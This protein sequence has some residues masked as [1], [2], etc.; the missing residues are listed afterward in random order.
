M[1]RFLAIL[2]IITVVVFM[3]FRVADKVNLDVKK[4]FPFFNTEEYASQYIYVFDR[5]TGAIMYEKNAQSKTFP[6]SLTKIMT[7]IVALEH[8]DDLTAIAPIDTE[9]QSE[10]FSN[11]AMM[12]GFNAGESVTYRDLL[13]GT[14]LPS[15]AEAANSLAVHVAGSVENFVQMMNDKAIELG[16]NSTHYTSPEGLHNKDQYTTASDMGKLLD[17]AL[18][19]EDFK[20]VFTKETFQTTSTTHHPDGIFLEST[21]LAS[22]N[23]EK[24]NG[25]KIIGGKSGTTDEAGQCW[26]T[27]GL[28]DDREYIS[29]VM[30]APLEDISHPDNKQIV[31]TL[32]L[33]KKIKAGEL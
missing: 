18:D 29:I 10:M 15:G 24:Q 16:L 26:A 9:T 19:N 30:G 14:M 20:A 27:L 21:V 31:D 33:Y 32:K 2:L 4:D 7:T 22:L 3:L 1:R 5:E 23:K 28:V 11:N 12:A 6:A 17:Y 8:I 25:F 13:Y